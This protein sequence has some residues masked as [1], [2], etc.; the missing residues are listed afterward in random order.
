MHTNLATKPSRRFLPQELDLQLK[1][2]EER[3]KVTA[4]RLR[5]ALL[6]HWIEQG[7]ESVA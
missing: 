5:Q 2:A 3:N 7:S 1:L 6:E 4:R